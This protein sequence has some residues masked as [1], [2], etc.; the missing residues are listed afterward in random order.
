MA[1]ASSTVEVPGA[2]PREVLELVLDP[3]RHLEVDPR[4]VRVGIMIGPDAAG[5]GSVQLVARL[6]FGPAWPDVYDVVLE[7][8]SRLTFTGAR[9]QPVRLVFDLTGSF[10]CEPT[11]IGTSVT[12]TCRLTFRLP[13]RWLDPLHRHWL[14]S[15]LDAEMGRILAA[16]RA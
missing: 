14:R 16:F 5:R 9:R 15:A 2:T 4:I 1:T 6:R 13:F 8:W 7:R 12:H 3:E 10:A 11:E